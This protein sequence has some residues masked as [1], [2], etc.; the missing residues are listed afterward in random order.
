MC[1]HDDGGLQNLKNDD[2]PPTKNSAKKQKIRVFACP[3]CSKIYRSRQARHRH[4]RLKHSGLIDQQE[5]MHVYVPM[6]GRNV[7]TESSS[8]YDEM[9]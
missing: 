2:G 4:C 1:S 3:H 5:T 8:P 6:P 7:A 9:F